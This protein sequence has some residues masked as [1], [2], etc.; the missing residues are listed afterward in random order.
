[1]KKGSNLHIRFYIY[2]FNTLS[3]QTTE[4][5]GS[6]MLLLQ[7]RETNLSYL[8]SNSRM[9]NITP[10]VDA[11]CCRVA[12]NVN[13]LLFRKSGINFSLTWGAAWIS[14]SVSKNFIFKRGKKKK[15]EKWK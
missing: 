15:K 8:C 2:H 12:R 13:S 4:H 10:E 9:D 3:K 1:M 5:P 14:L 11:F 6:F 7:E